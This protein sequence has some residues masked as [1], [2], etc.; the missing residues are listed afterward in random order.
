M[1]FKTIIKKLKIRDFRIRGYKHTTPYLKIV[2]R[3]KF[4]DLT[5]RKKINIGGV[6][7]C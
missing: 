5:I 1:L 2:S 4:I 6:T 7:A 3:V